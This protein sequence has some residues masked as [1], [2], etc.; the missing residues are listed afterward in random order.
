VSCGG[1]RSTA[2]PRNPILLENFAMNYV[3][4]RNCPTAA[5]ILDRAVASAPDSF[6]IRAL[7]ARVDFEI[8]R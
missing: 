7:R 4:L 5:Q 2:S 1:A 3:A 6:T 8:E